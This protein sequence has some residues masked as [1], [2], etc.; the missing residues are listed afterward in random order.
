MLS[1][2]FALGILSAS[3]ENATAPATVTADPIV[4]NGVGSSFIYPVFSRW[5][6]G[7]EQ[8]NRVNI[9]YDPEGS[10]VGLQRLQT[11][12][13]DFAI[14]EFPL[15]ADQLK[16]QNL[17]QFPL[18]IGGVV[19]CV[20]VPD[21]K[22]RQIVFDGDLLTKIYTGKITKWNDAAIQQLN[23]DLEFPNRKI[24]P[25][26]RSDGSGTA[27]AFSQYL[28]STSKTWKAKYGDNIAIDWPVGIGGTG[29]VEIAAYVSTIPYSLGFVEYAYA[30]EN[31]LAYTQL[32]NAAGKTVAPSQEAFASAA[33]HV[34]WTGDDDFIIDLINQPG[35]ETWPIVALSYVMMSQTPKNASEAQAFL[36]FCQWI[37]QQGQMTAQQ[38]FFAA[39]P[40]DA[41]AVIQ[42][43]LKANITLQGT[44]GGPQANSN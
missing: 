5:I 10:L 9:S 41:V 33:K 30:V 29:N 35:D 20:N 37:F 7:Y 22:A 19:I 1:L 40:D 32:K 26:F 44:L 27:W 13:S 21:L 25:V 42:S 17:V 36:K 16:A 15:T 28:G 6:I 18:V 4:V 31:R 14:S 39:I 11:G 24:T 38:L 2:L 23:P 34:K 8:S 12:T 3:T 43:Y